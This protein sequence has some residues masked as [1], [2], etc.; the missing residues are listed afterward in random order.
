MPMFYFFKDPQMTWP[1]RIQ[2]MPS[3]SHVSI[4][5]FSNSYK[6]YPLQNSSSSKQLVAPR[7]SFHNNT[8]SQ[9]PHQQQQFQQN[10]QQQQQYQHHNQF[11]YVPI[12]NS[13]NSP[14][15]AHYPPS[16][17]INH[18]NHI[19]YTTPPIENLTFEHRESSNG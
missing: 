2:Q 18:F 19:S 4:P 6:H 8:T 5:N 9:I 12:S 7:R 3:T 1:P 15:F 16:Q 10:Y 13:N 17:Q 14:S 11:N